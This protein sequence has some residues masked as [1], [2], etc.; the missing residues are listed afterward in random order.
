MSCIK[1]TYSLNA[2]GWTDADSE[3]TDC[4]RVELLLQV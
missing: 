3:A 4:Q 2:S 1:Y